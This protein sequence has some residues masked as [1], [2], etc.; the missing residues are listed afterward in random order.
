[1]NAGHA[2]GGQM[3]TAAFIQGSDAC[4]RF[5]W[6]RRAPVLRPRRARER[7]GLVRGGEGLEGVARERVRAILRVASGRPGSARAARI[8]G[9]PGGRADLDR[10]VGDE[11]ELALAARAR[12]LDPLGDELRA[13]LR[14]AV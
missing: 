2:S 14:L 11:D 3:N 8:G 1:M 13:Q 10:A 9:G 4:G 6:R 12:D 7:G 5:I